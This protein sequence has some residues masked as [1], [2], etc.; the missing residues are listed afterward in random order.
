MRFTFLRLELVLYIFVTV[1]AVTV[2]NDIQTSQNRTRKDYSKSDG[3]L[4][5]SRVNH[6]RFKQFDG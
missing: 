1:S 5:G 2:N 3:K 4:Q 6:F